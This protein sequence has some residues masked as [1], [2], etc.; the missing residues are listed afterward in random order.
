MEQRMNVFIKMRK[1]DLTIISEG[2]I[3]EFQA[4]TIT[5]AQPYKDYFYK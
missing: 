4:L 2:M 3:S 5:E 1:E